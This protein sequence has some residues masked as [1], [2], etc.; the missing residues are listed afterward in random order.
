MHS[1]HRKKRETPLRKSSQGILR[2]QIGEKSPRAVVEELRKKILE[3]V[4]L[5]SEQTVRILEA[6]L[7][8]DEK[9]KKR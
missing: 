8:E 7:N 6:W 4:D 1:Q 9:K 3:L 2:D 5:K